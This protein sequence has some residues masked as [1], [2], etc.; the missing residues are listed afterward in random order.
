MTSLL[1]CQ[2]F[3]NPVHALF[4]TSHDYRVTG[5]LYAPVSS[6]NEAS[7]AAPLGESAHLVLH[8]ALIVPF[9]DVTRMEPDYTPPLRP[10]RLVLGACGNES[11]VNHVRLFSG[12]L[13][14]ARDLS[15]VCCIAANG[16]IKCIL[17]LPIARQFPTVGSRRPPEQRLYA[18]G[19][20]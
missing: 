11:M 13:K 10:R 12:V 8:T 2:S 1:L 18:P 3:T 4:I 16:N 19:P 20:D 7:S 14:E 9:L 5:P 17:W 6:K 15:R